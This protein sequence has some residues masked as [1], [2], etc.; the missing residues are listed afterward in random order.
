MR[1]ISLEDLTNLFNK[2]VKCSYGPY[3]DRERIEIFNGSLSLRTRKDSILFSYNGNLQIIPLNNL[4]ND[5][6]QS[7]HVYGDLGKFEYPFTKSGKCTYYGA[8]L[9]IPL[10]NEK[11]IVVN[12]EKFIF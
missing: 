3:R 2:G 12:G 6:Q 8:H 7:F 4:S 10:E 1:N 11:K 9:T 5:E